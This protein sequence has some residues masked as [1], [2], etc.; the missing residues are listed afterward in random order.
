MIWMVNAVGIL[1]LA[2]ESLLI[3]IGFFRYFVNRNNTFRDVYFGFGVSAVGLSGLFV[4][5]GAS[6]LGGHVPMVEYP[7][8]L[9]VFIWIANLGASSALSIFYSRYHGM[10]AWNLGFALISREVQRMPSDPVKIEEVRLM[11]DKVRDKLY[12][13]EQSAREK[14]DAGV[15]R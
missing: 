15:G 3:A 6:L 12:Q 1:M 7:G 10:I 11:V 14:S 4:F 2:A 8:L 9:A 13:A 5:T